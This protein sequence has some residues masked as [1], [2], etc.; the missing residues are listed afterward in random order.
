MMP[1]RPRML[2]R[3]DPAAA[4]CLSDAL[5]RQIARRLAAW[6]AAP[7]PEAAAGAVGP[8]A[9]QTVAEILTWGRAM[10]RLVGEDPGMAEAWRPWLDRFAEYEREFG[11]GSAASP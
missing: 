6:P 4:T 9:P 3:M 7:L 5:R 1:Q 2:G 8:Q 11:D 10:R